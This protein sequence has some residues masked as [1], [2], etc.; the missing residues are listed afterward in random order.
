MACGLKVFMDETADAKGVLPS[1]CPDK[2][3]PIGAGGQP[4]QRPANPSHRSTFCLLITALRFKKRIKIVSIFFLSPPIVNL[5]VR[6]GIDDR[7]FEPKFL[8]VFLDPL[9]MLDP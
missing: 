4:L 3:G 5:D 2:P 1:P 7:R 6:G 8:L 9:R